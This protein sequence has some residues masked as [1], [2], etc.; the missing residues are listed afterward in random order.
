MIGGYEETHVLS[1][2]L[3][4]SEGGV[5]VE[6]LAQFAAGKL[7]SDWGWS[8]NLTGF[9]VDLFV[10]A[11]KQCSSAREG[12]SLEVLVSVARQAGALL[13]LRRLPLEQQKRGVRQARAAGI[14]QVLHYTVGRNFGGNLVLPLSLYVRGSIRV[15][16]ACARLTT[17]YTDLRRQYVT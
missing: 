9:V 15:H 14:L 11:L 16:E 1:D 17:N 7:G 5:L 13:A 8:I 6:S 12:C 10:S 2:S 4:S 3:I